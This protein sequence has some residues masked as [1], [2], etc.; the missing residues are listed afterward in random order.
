MAAS[1]Q[2]VSCSTEIQASKERI[3]DVLTA[4]ATFEQWCAA[5]SPGSYFEGD[6]TEGSTMRFLAANESGNAAGMV[7]R[8]ERHVP[9]EWLRLEHIGVVDNGLAVFEGEEY[10]KLIPAIEEY[11]LSEVPGGFRLSVE[12]EVPD[13]YIAFFSQ[14]WQDALNRIKALA[15]GD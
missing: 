10:E 1:K 2:K 13:S 6:W 11:R 5:F 7:T 3:W 15:E 4:P 9:A 14:A 12:T 8:V